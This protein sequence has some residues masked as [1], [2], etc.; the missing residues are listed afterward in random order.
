MSYLVLWLE[1][2]VLLARRYG[3]PGI[4]VT[5]L[6]VIAIQDCLFDDYVHQIE[7]IGNDKVW[8]KRLF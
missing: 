6:H 5:I 2:K 7:F 8:G 3:W 4:L 1:A